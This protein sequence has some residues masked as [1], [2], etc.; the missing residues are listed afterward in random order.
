MSA[1]WGLYK[2]RR[3]VGRLPWGTFRATKK[4]GV[5]VLCDVQ[6]GKDLVPVTIWDAHNMTIFEVA[7]YITERVQ[8][9]KAGK[10]ARHN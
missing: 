9:A 5:T 6:G 7:K 8:R 2:M 1:A 3:D 10:D 4:I